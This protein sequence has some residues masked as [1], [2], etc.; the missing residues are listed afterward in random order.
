MQHNPSLQ[1]SNTSNQ[2]VKQ[3]YNEKMA[4]KL[5][6]VIVPDVHE[7]YEK[8][9]KILAKYPGLWIVFLGDWFDSFANRGEPTYATFG[10][11]NWLKENV[12][13]PLYTFLWGNH[14]LHYAFPINGLMCSGWNKNKLAIIRNHLGDTDKGWK[15]FK[16]THWL[17]SSVPEDQRGNIENREYL[18]SHAGVHPY[19]LHPVYGFGK[20][21]INELGKEALYKVRYEK[22]VTAPLVCGPGRD[23]FSSARAG[24]IVWLDWDREFVPIEGLNQIVGHTPGDNVRTKILNDKNGALMSI[25]YCLDTH[26]NH[27][28]LVFDDGTL[29]I[30]SV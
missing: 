22:V 17:E 30:E 6:G 29:Q 16:L 9:L 20:N 24:G 28:I 3:W 23:K 8:L 19:F 27:V 11:C 13:N 12:M 4:K 26:L 7:Q 1:H 5:V 18:I 2:K 10:I 15:Q 14:D 21:Y 25:N